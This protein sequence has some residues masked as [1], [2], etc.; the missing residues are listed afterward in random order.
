MHYSFS[1]FIREQSLRK[2]IHPFNKHFLSTCSKV[3]CKALG[4]QRNKA[5]LPLP[6]EVGLV[7]QTWGCQT[8]VSSS[9]AWAQGR[10][11][12]PSL[13]GV[14]ATWSARWVANGKDT[15][16]GHLISRAESPSLAPAEVTGEAAFENPGSWVTPSCWLKTMK[17]MR[18]GLSLQHIPA[19]TDWYTV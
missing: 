7:W 8:K 13:G 16:L 10:L 5:E 1:V 19:S 3:P 15:S 17:S 14:G 18:L 4:L 9:S 11:N 2:V 6:G 12:F